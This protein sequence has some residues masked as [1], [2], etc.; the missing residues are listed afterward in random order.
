MATH[1]AIPA[2]NAIKVPEYLAPEIAVLAEPIGVATHGFNCLKAKRINLSTVAIRGAGTIG[3]S[4][5]L[6]AGGETRQTK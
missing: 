4:T 6:V 1:L 2:R 5:L 3:L